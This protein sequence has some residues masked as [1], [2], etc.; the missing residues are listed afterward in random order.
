M[1]P[2]PN[3]CLDTA[4]PYCTPARTR[5]HAAACPL[6]HISACSW[7]HMTACC[8][9]PPAPLACWQKPYSVTC[10]WFHLLCGQ[11]ASPDA[12]CSMLMPGQSRKLVLKCSPLSLPVPRPALPP[13]LRPTL[14][15]EHGPTGVAAG[16][17]VVAQEK[18]LQS[19]SGLGLRVN[20]TS[21]N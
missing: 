9:P 19:G 12:F 20:L 1:P 16:P 10:P 2:D 18:T 11:I 8:C 13:S 4:M 5:P 17:V 6:A 7:I 15:P 21:L 14:L 3:C